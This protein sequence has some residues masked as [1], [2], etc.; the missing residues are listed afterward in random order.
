VRHNGPLRNQFFIQETKI[1]HI[2]AHSLLYVVIVLFQVTRKHTPQKARKTSVSDDNT[3]RI[4]EETL[5]KRGENVPV[6]EVKGDNSMQSNKPKTD[7][8]ET[9]SSKPDPSN[10]RT[11]RKESGSTD[12]TSPKTKQS[13]PPSPKTKQSTPPKSAKKTE[14]GSAKKSRRRL[15]ANFNVKP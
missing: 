2:D 11:E 5:E 4:E 1:K 3:S 6:R 8:S 10:S 9:I 7:S 12:S 13:K 14:T 15:A